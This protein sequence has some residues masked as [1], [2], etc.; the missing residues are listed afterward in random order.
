M[1]KYKYDASR[2]YRLTGVSNSGATSL[3]DSTRDQTFNDLTG[4]HSGKTAKT[5][6]DE[7]NT[8]S[9]AT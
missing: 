1:A 5:L 7:A 4:G 6:Y 2:I 8:A 9:A 3:S